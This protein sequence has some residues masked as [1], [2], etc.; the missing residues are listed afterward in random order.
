[1]AGI[2]GSSRSCDERHGFQIRV[3]TRL[4]PSSWKQ[5]G[6]GVQCAT[7][8]VM[9]VTMAKIGEPTRRRREKYRIMNRKGGQK[10]KCR[11]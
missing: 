8:G 11:G 5:S 7:M 6:G 1:M 9:R 4:R 2:K 3:L 10:S